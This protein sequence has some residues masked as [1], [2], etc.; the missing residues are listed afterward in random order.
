M[1]WLI[2]AVLTLLSSSVGA[3]ASV[4]P[5]EA[6]AQ[7]QAEYEREKAQREIQRQRE[8][9]AEAERSKQASEAARAAEVRKREELERQEAAAKARA[10]RA[11][12]PITYQSYARVQTYMTYDEVTEIIGKPGQ[13]LSR[14]YVAGYDTVMYQ[15]VNGDGSNMNALFQNDRLVQKAQFGLR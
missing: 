15:W 9:A 11:L 3:A 6:A 10:A 14:S 13:E 4:D 7:I 1:R 2:L 5:R 8:A 12:L